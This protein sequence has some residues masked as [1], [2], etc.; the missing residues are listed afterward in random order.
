VTCVTAGSAVIFQDVT[1]THYPVYERD[2]LLNSNA[3]F[4]YGAFLALE[5]ALLAGDYEGN[6]DLSF[7]FTFRDDGIYVFKD[8]ADAT[9][10][11]IIAVMYQGGSCPK[12]LLYEAQKPSALLRVGAS[13][14][15]DISLT[16]DW[17]FFFASI[18]AFIFLFFFLG[19]IVS[20]IVNKSW[21]QDPAKQFIK[22]QHKHYAKVAR[23]DIDDPKAVIS[24]NSDASA[25]QFRQQGADD[26]AKFKALEKAKGAAGVP[27][28]NGASAGA[29]LDVDALEHL[30]EGLG[31]EADDLTHLYD[32]DKDYM[33]I[34]VGSDDEDE[35][36]RIVIL[37]L[38][39]YLEK[40][41]A[42]LKGDGDPYSSSSDEDAAVQ[43][44]S[45]SSEDSDEE[46]R[47]RRANQK[48]Q[49]EAAFEHQVNNEESN[50]EN[51]ADEERQDI[52]DGVLG[53]VYEKGDE[54]VARLEQ[55]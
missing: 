28:A 48:R 9:K 19:V 35:E 8:A 34:G 15:E 54:V 13:K 1:A 36:P 22:Y 43:A 23:C 11:T 50:I 18:I 4:D 41:S 25:F 45:S 27:D 49:E 26:S 12:D 24:I 21:D 52:N 37:R 42:N 31:E 5:S 16:P 30:K 46:R 6:D 10:Q 51:A 53:D 47:R 38:R 7:V 44:E 40:I 14:R 20:Y 3:L 17:A 29:V 39:K 2:N 55:M 32:Q 33:P